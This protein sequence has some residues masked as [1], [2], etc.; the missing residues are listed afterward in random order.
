MNNSHF[1]FF[2]VAII[3]LVVC[4]LNLPIIHSLWIHSFDDGTY[5]HA[6]LIPLI[7]FFL[8]WKASQENKLIF[9]EKPSIGYVILLIISGLLLFIT[10]KAQISLGYWLS[11]LCIYVFCLLNIFRFNIYLVF[12][13]SYIIFLIPVW[14]NLVPI[15]QK[16]SIVVVSY[17]MTLTNIPIFVEQQFITI[18][19]GVF[20]I[21]GGCS[22]LRYFLV[23][24]AISYLFIYLHIRNVK[25]A[26]IFIAFSLFGALLTNWIRI[27][28]LI[29]IGHYTDMESPLMEDHN[30]FGWYI[31]IPFMFLL[32][33]FGEKLT[34]SQEKQEPKVGHASTSISR[35]SVLIASAILLISSTSFTYNLNPA[36]NSE[37]IEANQLLPITLNY[38]QH[39]MSDKSGITLHTFH[40]SGKYLEHKP[41]QFSNNL[42]PS[43]WKSEE[44]TIINDWKVI[45]IKRGRKSAVIF[46]RYGIGN[47]TAHSSSKFK[48]YR[49]K[50][51]L[52]N[53]SD[54]T[55]Y[56]TVISDLN[57]G[58]NCQGLF[59]DIT[60]KLNDL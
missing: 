16:I 48:L 54:T 37:T 6:F 34:T 9:R 17:F 5:S 35:K 21:A 29:L 22:G 24:Q 40:Y 42:I 52:N 53:I 20:E 30:M 33:W 45:F 7:S 3:S 8:F 38:D 43:G 2:F 32:F 47:L 59:E 4:L 55:L 58:N 39:V 46:T 18:P 26:I 51:A 31:F 41:T 15:L 36:V 28:L 19:A 56:W 14:G 50:E 25:S 23:S 12:P 11:F 27:T 13:A 57:C 10:S 49:L 44:V 1:T 60:K